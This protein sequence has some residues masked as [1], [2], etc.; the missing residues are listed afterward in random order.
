VCAGVVEGGEGRRDKPG[1][2]ALTI[3]R[4]YLFI[5]IF[6]PSDTSKTLNSFNFCEKAKPNGF[7]EN[8]AYMTSEK[9]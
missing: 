5:V 3:Q 7:L 8:K 6:F 1:I 9:L 2:A 4:S